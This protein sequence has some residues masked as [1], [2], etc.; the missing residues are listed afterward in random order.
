MSAHAASF[1]YAA[2][3]RGFD[4]LV[5]ALALGLAALLMLALGG[6]SSEPDTDENAPYPEASPLLYEVADAQGEV[7]G[8]L[9]GTIHALP[10]DVD[11]RTPAIEQ[12]VTEAD[13]LLVEVAGLGQNDEV[14]EVFLELSQ[15]PGLPPLI[16]RVA[17][18]FREDL[19]A[20]IDE[21]GTS[22]A[23]L[24]S[25]EDWAAAIMLA[26]LDAPGDPKY[27]VD[28]A[29]IT[30]FKGRKITGFET[31]REQLGIFDQ[32]ASEDQ[33]A[34]LEGTV[35]DWA[36]STDNR[37]KLVRAWIAGDV[38]TLEAATSE[39][40]M[41]D[42]QIREALLDNRNRDWLK[43]LEPIFDDGPKPLVA[44]GAAHIVG[45]DGLAEQLKQR[46]FTVTRVQ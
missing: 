18:Q 36:S 26:R 44:V 24:R 5:R 35:E 3:K 16:E 9:L 43:Q 13:L 41:A 29:L 28:R 42:P 7:E 38:Q 34:L 15:S 23:I 37:D 2:F 12:V 39:G 8:W 17:P 30:G 11:W 4:W 46:G 6:C 14:A 31:A 33:R 32:L 19:D 1:S 10:E 21:L 20:M 22:R 27:G 25:S 40:I 45:P